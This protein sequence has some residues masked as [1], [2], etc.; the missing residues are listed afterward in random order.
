M[1]ICLNGEEHFF[2][3][4]NTLH[5]INEILFVMDMFYDIHIENKAASFIY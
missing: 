5:L 4:P 3:L 2:M 1:I